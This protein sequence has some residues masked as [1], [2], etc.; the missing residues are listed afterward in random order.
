M[1]WFSRKDWNV[2]AIIFERADLYQVSGQRVKG[3]AADKARD[4]AKG[5]PRTILWAVF[6]QKGAHQEGGLGPA[7]KNVPPETVK[8]LQRELPMNSTVLEILKTLESRAEE[9]LARP[10]SWTGYPKR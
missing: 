4:G 2:I 5:H 6:D 3:S 9:K 7:A 10:L 1:G 8:K